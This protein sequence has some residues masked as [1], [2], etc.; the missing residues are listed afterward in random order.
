M[1]F[2]EI[3]YDYPLYRPPSEA[4]SMI[5]Q[6]T[7]GCSF[8]KCSF[9][10]M[11]RTKDYVERPWAEI[12]SEIDMA[13]KYYPNTRRVFLA[14]G[15]ALNLPKENMLQ[16]LRYIRSQFG[17]LERISCYAMPKN[18]LQKR[19]EELQELRAEGLSM[20]YVG[21]ESGNDIVL[22]KVTKGATY[23]SIVE[24]CKKAKR[25]GYMLSCM[26]ILGLGGKT[27]TREHTVDTARILSETAPDYVGALTLYL[28]DGV[29]DEFLDKFGEPFIPLDDIDVLDEIEGLVSLFDP[30]SPVVFRA[31]HAS[32]VYSLGGTIP[33]DK[34]KLIS[35]VRG[36]R[37]RPEMLKPK[38]LRRF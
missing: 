2:M 17:E 21:I 37:T 30:A 32:N 4:N 12:K 7:L 15:D 6:V 35:L 1:S 34:E 5:F 13:A 20:L 25:N 33:D 29:R 27:Y 16:I 19:D 10:N 11:Y 18:L 28:E 8:N 9:C 3:A 31:N 23:K 26:V 36:L 38:S 14:D 22:K 24:A